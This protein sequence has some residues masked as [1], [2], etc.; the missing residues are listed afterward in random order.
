[1]FVCV[2]SEAVTFTQATQ[3]AVGTQLSLS[4]IEALLYY[5]DG[6]PGGGGSLRACRYDN[7]TALCSGVGLAA[8]SP[9]PAAFVYESGDLFWS[10]GGGGALVQSYDSKGL[11][12]VDVPR[13]PLLFPRAVHLAPDGLLYLVNS[14]ANT[15]SLLSCDPL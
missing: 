6:R 8:P 5:G 7:Y 4:P 15:S 11:L 3:P 2:Q 13:P 14:T 1:M 9:L 12:Q 10:G